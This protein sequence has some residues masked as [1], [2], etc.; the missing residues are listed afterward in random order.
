MGKDSP[1]QSNRDSRI[2]MRGV[3]GR[4]PD[5]LDN[6]ASVAD[7]G[8]WQYPFQGQQDSAVSPSQ[9]ETSLAPATEEH[10]PSQPLHSADS[11]PPQDVPSPQPSAQPVVAPAPQPA[12][13]PRRLYADS[14]YS[15]RKPIPPP[16]PP[17]PPKQPKQSKKN[18]KPVRGALATWDPPPLFQSYSQA[19]KLAQLPTC[20]TPIENLLRIQGSRDGLDMSELAR[21]DST[22]TED[23]GS[24]GDKAD[25]IKKRHRRNTSGSLMKLDW[26]N[27]IYVLLTSGYL[28]QYAGAGS[29]DRLPEKI[30]PLSKES[31]AFASDLIPGRHWVLRVCSVMEAEPV[32]VD[33]RSMFS[34]MHFRGT[35]RR[36]AST[37]LMVFD[38]AQ[39][40]ESWITTLRREIEHLG[41][42][43]KLSETGSPKPEEAD[44]TDPPRQILPAHDSHDVERLVRAVSPH[45]IHSFSSRRRESFIASA[46]LHEAY[47]PSALPDDESMTNSV[48]SQDSRQ[49]D[50]LRDSNNRYSHISSGQRTMFTSDTGSSPPCSPAR[51]SFTSNPSN[52]SEEQLTSW[53]DMSRDARQRPNASAVHERRQSLQVVAAHHRVAEFHPSPVE[54]PQQPAPQLRESHSDHFDHNSFPTPPLSTSPAIPNFSVPHS[55]KRFS[56]VLQTPSPDNALHYPDDEQISHLQHVQ[57]YQQDGYMPPGSPPPRP[58]RSPPQGKKQQNYS[59]FPTAARHSGRKLPPPALAYSRPLSIVPDQPSPSASPPLSRERSLAPIE[60]SKASSEYSPETFEAP[61]VPWAISGRASTSSQRS[62]SSGSISRSKG[63]FKNKLARGSSSSSTTTD[64]SSEKTTKKRGGLQALRTSLATKISNAVMSEGMSFGVPYSAA[65]SIPISQIPVQYR[66][67]NMMSKGTSIASGDAETS[68]AKE[69]VLKAKIDDEAPEAH[70]VEDVNDHHDHRDRSSWEGNVVEETLLPDL[71]PQLPYMQPMPPMPPLP[72]LSQLPLPRDLPPV[73]QQPQSPRQQYHHQQQHYPQPS[74]HQQHHHHQYHYDEHDA[75]LSD[76]QHNRQYSPRQARAR[77]NSASRQESRSPITGGYL[78]RSAEFGYSN[79]AVHSRQPQTYTH[80]QPWDDMGIPV[81]RSP[82]HH[83]ASPASI[84]TS[85]IT[86]DGGAVAGADWGRGLASPRYPKSPA[87]RPI[88]PRAPSRNGHSARPGSSKGSEHRHSTAQVV[89]GPPPAPPPTC[90]LPP[91]PPLPSKGP[92]IDAP[93]RALQA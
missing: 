10:A 14:D 57:Q 6:R 77:S 2:G 41:G 20:T 48:Y 56:G 44:K 7:F 51:D 78:Q 89:E 76:Q 52:L 80:T 54:Q 19:I 24:I 21:S 60:D 93:R 39:D 15:F 29:S 81:H 9:K 73:Q 47:T 75:Y 8:S 37:F 34:R 23:T 12:P 90:A 26:D 82:L 49:L 84:M 27:K 71:P 62:G 13:K 25:K 40:M 67:Q 45:D 4:R 31:A 87:S 63:S 3:F 72:R 17:K 88:T 35:E 32:P 68:S 92:K 58:P 91:L 61:R 59:P 42:K 18:D 46:G 53:N 33:S 30:L 11:Q 5:G 43:K 85:Y 36:D 86:T 79:A 22:S 16:K 1:T 83:P 50:N 74:P 55:S 28:L 64:D 65:L 38:N 69:I 70:G 66:P